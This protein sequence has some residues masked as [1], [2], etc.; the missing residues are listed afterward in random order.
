MLKKMSL[1]L[2]MAGLVGGAF[3][4][5]EADVESTFFPYKKGF[6]SFPGLSAG[7]VISKDN[8]DQFKDA[9]AEGTYMMIKN[10]YTTVTVGETI[11]FELPKEYIQATKDNLNKTQLGAKAG[12]NISGF[13]AGR[14]FPEEPDAKDPRAGEKL[15]WNY[16]Y[17]LNW[18]DNGVIKP[19]IMKYRNME[20]G[21]VERTL[22]NHFSFLN[23]KHRIKDA[24]VPEITPNP[25]DLF[26]AIYLQVVGP[27]DLKDTKLLI[28]RFD[29]DSKLDDNYLYL[30]FQ[31]RVRRLAAGQVTDSFLGS[32]MMI[33][34]FEGYNGRVSDMKWE[35]KGTKNVLLPMWK[36]NEAPL[37]DEIAADADGY[38]YIKFGG[39]GGCFLQAP[40]QL[41]KS[42][43]LEATPVDPNHPIGKRVFYMDAQLQNL[44]GAIEIYDRKGK[45]W[46]VWSVGKSH[47]DYHLPINKGTGIGIDDGF[48]MVDV[49]ANHC[50]TG[51]F[52]GE[53]DKSQTPPQK[54]QVQYMRGSD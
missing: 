29:D 7:T 3:A 12:D 44:N 42:Y 15:A 34:D 8:V 31:R 35:Y 41:R 16:K 22:T 38:K 4:A 6:P 32:D 13:V 5:T 53:V 36:H 9:L 48:Q 18:G 2:V 10:G 17:G 51:H 37:G 19:L 54:F 39:K 14:P 30:G 47:P 40:W 1:A 50:T 11:D 33:E 21:A 43:V 23:F 26:R 49:Q 52:R 20:S 28:Q 46:K 25:S 24:P 27:E 45:L